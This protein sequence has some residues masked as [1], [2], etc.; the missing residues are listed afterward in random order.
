MTAG[1]VGARAAAVIGDVRRGMAARRAVSVATGIGFAG[2]LLLGIA[3]GHPQVGAN[4]T[5]GAFVVLYASGSPVRRRAFVL[6]LML[7]ALPVSSLLGS[8]VGDAPVLACLVGGVYAMV[9]VIA[10][11]ALRIGPPREFFPIMLFCT[12]VSMPM[13]FGP[14]LE[15]SGWIMAGAAWGAVVALAPVVWRS[16]RIAEDQA[17]AAIRAVAAF[18]DAI[19]TPEADALQHAAIAAVEQA[20]TTAGE[21]YGP[22]GLHVRHRAERVERLLVEAISVAVEQPGGVDRSIGAAVRELATERRVAVSAA[23]PDV[24]AGARLERAVVELATPPALGDDPEVLPAP[25][26]RAEPE[27]GWWAPVPWWLTHRNPR[28]RAAIRSALAVALGLGSGFALD[29]ERPGWIAVAAIAVLQGA[30]AR[31]VRQRAI[32]RVVGTTIGFVLA[33][34]L[35]ALDPSLWVVAIVIVVLQ[36]VIEGIVT[37]S[38][39]LAA[40]FITPVTVLLVDLSL[41]VER[42]AELIPVRVLDTAIGCALGVVVLLATRSRHMTGR[43]GQQQARVMAA[44][45]SVLGEV[46]GEHPDDVELHHRRRE[47]RVALM[48]MRLAADEAIGDALWRTPQADARWPISAILERLA[49]L[50][51][52]VSPDLLET[53]PADDAWRGDLRGALAELTEQVAQFGHVTPPAALPV[54]DVPGLPRTTA[55]LRDLATLLTDR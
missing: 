55:G 31:V 44:I 14:S 34:G 53:S 4:A 6:A 52:A 10:N 9:W 39:G 13:S 16:G 17:N 33:A 46:I 43:L 25:A 40:V 32:H 47:L 30:T 15:R 5:Q 7:V 26:E 28:R 2:P 3:L 45:G 24:P 50:A 19:G 23:W 21:T 54:P 36:M 48:G 18:V 20:A 11:A 12:A 41:G 27:R 35:L 29:L 49:V 38:Y 51:L 22:N 42:S 37:V 8:L 1:S